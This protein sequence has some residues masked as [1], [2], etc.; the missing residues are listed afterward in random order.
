MAAGVVEAYRQRFPNRDANGKT[1]MWPAQALETY[2]CKDP[3][4]RANCPTN[5]STDIAG[6][7]AVLPRLIALPASAGATDAQ[8]TAWKAQLALLPPL[9]VGPAT[10]KGGAN[11]KKILPISQGDGFPTAGSGHRS[12]S[13]NTEMCEYLPLIKR[14][15]S[16][17]GGR[18]RVT[19][20][21]WH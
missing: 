6:L 2:Q 10:K 3:T 15:V 8:K 7:M 20:P 5:P 1:D 21:D 16:A 4:S 12:N 17:W 14:S 19:K 11:A 18:P 9:P 13:E